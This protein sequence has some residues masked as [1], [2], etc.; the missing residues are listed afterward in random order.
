[1]EITSSLWFLLWVYA[2]PT[3]LNA[4][5]HRKKITTKNKKQ[6]AMKKLI[7]FTFLFTMI[8]IGAKAQKT[9]NFGVKGGVNFASIS[10]E[11]HLDPRSKTAIYLGALAEFSIGNK[12]S[13]QSEILYT[14]HFMNA[15]HVVY[16]G[17][18]PRME[19]TLDYIQ[20]PVLAKFYISKNIS[21]ELGPSYNILLNDKIVDISNNNASRSDFAKK[22]EFSGILGATY[23]FKKGF[24]TSVRYCKGLSKTIFND[25]INSFQFGIGF[26]F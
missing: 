19:F 8:T 20:V 23:K 10:T 9:T 1:M 3:I 22:D 5:R 2:L 7:L 12:F 6:T 26:M 4:A 16:G 24:F 21:L 11:N 13:I 15:Y 14:R 17:T 25:K 18:F